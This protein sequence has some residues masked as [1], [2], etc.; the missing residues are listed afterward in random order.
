MDIADIGDRLQAQSQQL[1]ADAAEAA[2][3]LSNEAPGARADDA[4]YALLVGALA[5]HLARS[6]AKQQVGSRAARVGRAFADLVQATEL[7]RDN[8]R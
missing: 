3:A 7:Y 2:G 4:T 5:I 8:I 1:V 6:T